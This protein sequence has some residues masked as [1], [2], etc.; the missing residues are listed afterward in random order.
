MTR[1]LIPTFVGVLLLSMLFI[2]GSSMAS[3]DLPKADGYR[4]IWYKISAGKEI[5]YSGGFA[6][7]PQQ[8]RPLAI[9]RKEVNKTFFVY[10]GTDE[11]NSTLLHM[12]SYFDHATGTV[13]RPRILLDKKTTDAHDNPCLAIDP[14]GYL[15]IFSN[16]HGPEKRSYI[17][18]STEP[19]SIDRFERIAQVSLSY[20][21][22]WWI[23]GHGILLIQN[24]YTD[25]RAVAFQTSSPDGRTWS[26]PKLLAQFKGHYSISYA[27]GQR[28][29]VA[30]NYHPHGL[31][32]RTNL[33]YIE[34]NDFGATWT[35]VDGKRVEIPLKEVINPTL[36]HDYESEKLLVYLKDIQF[37][38][39][40]RPIVMYINGATHLGDGAPRQWMLA[41]WS[42]N[43]WKLKPIVRSD[44]N[45]DFGQLYIEADGTWRLIAPTDPGPQPGM[46][47]GDVVMWTSHD[48]GATW[49]RFKT[50]THGA[51]QGGLRNQTYVR[52]PIDARDDFYAFWADG[53]PRNVSESHLYFTNKNGDHVWEL[54]WTLVGDSAK[55][56]VVQFK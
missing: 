42:G 16:T 32:T 20:S 6:T 41:H 56:E 29:A 26:E 44:H 17:H 31:D 5:K 33:Y 34:S 11:K 12:V 39:E 28:V 25:G 13:P 50:L 1:R 40:G 49:E 7:Y 21:D 45:Y 55:P 14:Q 48:E 35:T 3:D 2:G 19:Y 24:R 51:A 53:D 52:Q 23:D 37:D 36:V 4:G 22:P 27:R 10:G 8:I 38:A 46:T 15:W 18:R 9:Y 54:P 47:G 43:E 30:F